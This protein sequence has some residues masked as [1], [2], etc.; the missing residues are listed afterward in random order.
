MRTTKEIYKEEILIH[1]NIV[2]G[3]TALMCF[4]EADYKTNYIDGG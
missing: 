1:E 4:P 3:S 2:V